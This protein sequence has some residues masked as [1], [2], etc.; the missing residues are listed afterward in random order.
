MVNEK[1]AIANQYQGM[2]NYATPNLDSMGIKKNMSSPRTVR[3]HF[4][5]KFRFNK[6]FNSEKNVEPPGN[7]SY[8][9]N[10]FQANSN[11][12]EERR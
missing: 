5:G 9:A 8:N 1:F 10:A 7:Q 12:A 2:T 3:F 6:L 4:K 11:Q